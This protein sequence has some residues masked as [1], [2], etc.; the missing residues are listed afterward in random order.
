MCSLISTQNHKFFFF[1]FI[2]II[3]ARTSTI[4]AH[5]THFSIK[6]Y[7]KEKRYWQCA[8]E[9]LFIE[10]KFILLF[11]V[12]F[13]IVFGLFQSYLLMRKLC[14]CIIEYSYG[15]INGTGSISAFKCPIYKKNL[16]NVVIKFVGDNAFGC[17]GKFSSMQLTPNIH[18]VY[19]LQS[20]LEIIEFVPRII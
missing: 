12:N 14:F 20:L 10:Q 2:C 13:W 11:L 19:T 16:F 18:F 6:K 17:I 1:L 9:C 7:Q 4:T 5:D 15:K 8:N 3:F